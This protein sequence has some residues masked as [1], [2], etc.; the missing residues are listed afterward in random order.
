MEVCHRS[1]KAGRNTKSCS[2]LTAACDWAEGPAGRQRRDYPPFCNIACVTCLKH[3]AYIQREV[4]AASA[5]PEAPCRLVTYNNLVYDVSTFQHP[6]G[7]D[8]V[9]A[10][11]GQDISEAFESVGHSLHAERMLRDLCVGILTDSA[12]EEP[13]PTDKICTCMCRANAEDKGKRTVCAIKRRKPG[14]DIAEAKDISFTDGDS[15]I[16]ETTADGSE[17]QVKHQ[18]HEEGGLEPHDLIDFSKPLL[19]QIYYLNHADYKRVVDTPCC[20][21]TVFRLLPWDALEPI[22]K[23][24]WWMVPLFWIPVCVY[25]SY[26]ALQW[27][28]LPAF[29]FA[30]VCGILVWTLLEYCLHRFLFHFPEDNLP[31]C[32]WIRVVHF[33]LH[34]VHHMLPMDPL[35]LVMPPALLLFL[36][37]PVLGIVLLMLPGWFVHAA[38]PGGL[39]GYLLYDMIHYTTHHFAF[40][41]GI[42]HIRRMKRYHLKHHFKYPL[43]GFGVSSKIWDVV[44]GT[45]IP[46]T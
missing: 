7:N 45:T 20:K 8:L 23:T 3:G 22:T 33:L 12:A 21:A 30:F 35:R 26:T 43:L 14:A 42:E 16:S 40:L 39:T 34:A 38:W 27:I 1:G 31:D 36:S 24:T 15:E 5:Q 13:A 17:T 18:Q 28:S 19:P 6:G 32:G 44:F 9:E 29:L 46:D 11:I 37:I 2:I 10:Y 41:E 25:L 4:V